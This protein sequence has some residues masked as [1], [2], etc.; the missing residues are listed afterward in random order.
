MTD[1]DILVKKQ[2]ALKSWFLL[3]KYG[4]IPDIIKSPL[5]RKIIAEIGKHLPT[6]RKD[7]FPIEIHHRLFV[8]PEKNNKLDEAIDNAFEIDI[9][10][11]KAYILNDDIHL[12][13]L[14][15]HLYY[16]LVS[17]ESQLRQ[18]L[19]LE[20][21]KPESSPPIPEGFLAAPV[22]S[23][24]R[25]QRINAYRVLFFSLPQRI[26]FRF[27][28]GDIFPSLNWMKKRHNCGTLKALLYYPQ[29]LGKLVWLM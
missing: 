25:K 26:R 4:F 17:G 22:I 29:R 11:T 12:D 20:L 10:G 3:Q 28:A 16:H 2:D 24:S 27:L 1:C 18:Y 23:V 14:K 15:E 7:D 9:E 21:L 6:L 13:Y 19:D 5:H 8:E